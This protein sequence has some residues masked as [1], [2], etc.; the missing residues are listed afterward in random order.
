MKAEQAFR[1]VPWS[2][3]RRFTA[4]VVIAV[5]VGSAPLPALTRVASSKPIPPQAPRFVP[6]APGP[7]L[8]GA[9]SGNG[10]SLQL[11]THQ[12]SAAELFA[13]PSV[14]LKFS[15]DES[16]IFKPYADPTL[17]VRI[18]A[19][20][21]APKHPTLEAYYSPAARLAAQRSETAAH[22]ADL[23]REQYVSLAGLTKITD[24]WEAAA[25][26]DTARD[27]ALQLAN[28]LMLSAFEDTPTPSMFGGGSPLTQSQARSQLLASLTEAQAIGSRPVGERVWA[29]L[30]QTEF[31]PAVYR[32][33]VQV[34]DSALPGFV[35]FRVQARWLPTTQ[36][37][38]NV[39][40]FA[41]NMV[42]KDRQNRETL[43]LL[44]EPKP[45]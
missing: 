9:R 38:I 16:P 21:V 18:T 4:F 28:R 5:A 29:D 45:R 39:D 17:R 14:K 26:T 37:Q 8:G 13:Q 1:L 22:K 2:P 43:R 7:A 6:I 31:P 15:F 25:A 12:K 27:T 30:I 40:G 11:K 33:Q 24:P 23:A 32:P 35:N 44:L 36:T 41:V 42:A 34:T 3:G 19:P 20:N 10:L